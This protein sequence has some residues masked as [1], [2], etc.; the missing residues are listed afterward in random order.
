[1]LFRSVPSN[2]TKS[3]LKGVRTGNERDYLNG[4]RDIHEESLDFQKKVREVYLKVSQ[5]DERLSVVNC[6][7]EKGEMLPPEIIFE[8]ILETIESKKIFL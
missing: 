2:F 4:K 5:N 3:K 1:M 8:K 7:N 6:N